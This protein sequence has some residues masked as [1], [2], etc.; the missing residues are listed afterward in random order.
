MNSKREIVVGGL[1]G[2]GDVILALMILKAYN[3]NLG[4]IVVVS[5][6]KCRIG[7][8]R[9]HDIQ[10]DGAL[11]RVP[12]N[13]FPS[14]RIFEDKLYLIEPGLANHTYIVCTRDSFND[15]VKGLEW[16]I[17][18]YNPRFMLH[19]DIGGDSLIMGY[20]HRLGS[21]L[22]DTIARAVLTIIARKYGVRSYLAV[23][24]V[25]C[26]GGGG[27]LDPHELAANLKYASGKGALVK[28][29]I[30]PRDTVKTGYSVL[31]YADSGMLPMFLA[32]LQDKREVII[33]RA[34]LYGKYKIEPWYKCIYILDNPRFCEI[35]PI[36]KNLVG[37]GSIRVD[38]KIAR[39]KGISLSGL[40]PAG[41]FHELC[42]RYSGG[43]G[44]SYP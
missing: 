37:R 33:H 40:D 41:T 14:R 9:L 28:T 7:K 31:R 17:E 36:C 8:E 4:N 26:E 15:V 35:S 2:G 11:V 5:F 32:A 21:Y 38:G 29:I 22:T 43:G 25:G 42:I 19:S 20:E 39:P 12:P 23:A 10:V 27:E 34:Y 24:C 18:R 3:V 6:N 16:I 44:F 13:Y 30:L 1:G